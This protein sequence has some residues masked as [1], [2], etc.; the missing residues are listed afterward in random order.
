ML[1][2]EYCVDCGSE[3]E[4]SLEILTF[5][6]LDS[7][8]DQITVLSISALLAPIILKRVYV[9]GGKVLSGPVFD[10]NLFLAVMNAII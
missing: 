9:L 5:S 10:I 6:F 1:T 4:F 3:G 2:E 8:K 7:S